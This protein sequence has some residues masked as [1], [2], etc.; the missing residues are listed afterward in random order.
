MPKL[1]YEG[2]LGLVLG[3]IVVILDQ[4]GVK[5]PYVLWIA[6]ALAI[7]LCLDATIRSGWTTRKKAWGSG[8]VILSFGLFAVYLVYQLH[9]KSE[10]E[11]PARQQADERKA[12]TPPIVEAPVVKPI[13]KAHPARVPRISLATPLPSTPAPI[14]QHG[15]D[16]G[17][18][19]GSITTGPCSNVQVGGSNNQATTNCVPDR[20][21][22]SQQIATLR[23]LTRPFNVKVTLEMT[24]DGSGYG[25]ELTDALNMQPMDWRVGMWVGKEPR[26][27]SINIHDRDEPF[28]LQRFA[29]VLGAILNVPKANYFFGNDT[30]PGTI[31]IVV[32]GP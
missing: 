27:V 3:L 20:H 5:N 29:A 32:G 25:S 16:S 8:I 18:V 17:A 22:T 13:P 19:G 15:S 4:A 9:P 21:L 12:A 11:V 31:R 26:G 6:F 10:A 24:M 7:G 23:T 2:A 28:A 14:E 30:P 1:S